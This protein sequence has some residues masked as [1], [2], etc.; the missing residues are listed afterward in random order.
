M[1]QVLVF[2]GY[3]LPLSEV[4]TSP[5]W[6][7]WDSIYAEI[8]SAESAGFII[9]LTNMAIASSFPIPAGGADTHMVTVWV[10]E[11]PPSSVTV[12]VTV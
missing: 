1:N 4:T 12:R 10:S 11:A 6:R 3:W 8:P 7:G 9:L 5:F 2:I